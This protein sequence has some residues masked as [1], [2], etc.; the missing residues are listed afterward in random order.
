MD[1]M[2]GLSNLFIF[3]VKMELVLLKLINWLCR[4]GVGVLIKE[5]EKNRVLGG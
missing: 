3:I 5:G 2:L 1:W 4:E